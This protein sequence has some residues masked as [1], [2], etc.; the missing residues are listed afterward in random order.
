MLT[1]R[2]IILNAL[3][4]IVTG[5]FLYVAWGYVLGRGGDWLRVLF[6]NSPDNGE[7]LFKE[8]VYL[9]GTEKGPVAF[10]D[11]CPHLGC[12]LD[13]QS[14]SEKFQCPCHGSEFAIDGERIAGPAKRDMTRLKV[15]P[16]ERS[17]ECC[18]TLVIT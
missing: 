16:D 1:R 11:R 4:Y 12:R 18:V 17:G 9:V 10:D 8:S 5:G 7:V 2:E 13:Y 3:R 14:G 15:K 6:K